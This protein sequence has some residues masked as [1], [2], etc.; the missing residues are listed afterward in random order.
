MNWK[1]CVFTWRLELDTLCLR[2]A[3]PVIL[4]SIMMTATSDRP[5]CK[6]T[7]SGPRPFV[8]KRRFSS[9]RWTV[10]LTIQLNAGGPWANVNAVSSDFVTW[11][12]FA[13]RQANSSGELE[14]IDKPASDLGKRFYRVIRQ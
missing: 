11:T 7:A 9:C 12:E 4:F 8:S 14:V 10:R 2:M 6:V 1:T 13:T 3:T 5:T